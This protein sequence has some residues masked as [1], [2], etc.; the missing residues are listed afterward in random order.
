VTHKGAAHGDAA[1]LPPLMWLSVTAAGI[2]TQ[3]PFC[4]GLLVSVITIFKNLL[5]RFHEISSTG[6]KY[7]VSTISGKSEITLTLKR[8]LLD[9]R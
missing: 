9:D 7:S 8:L 1:C 2:I 6:K 3:V 5:I 4:F